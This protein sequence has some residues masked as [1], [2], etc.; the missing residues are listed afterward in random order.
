MPKDNKHPSQNS[1][2]NNSSSFDLYSDDKTKEIVGSLF[3]EFVEDGGTNY[4][5]NYSDPFL[6]S[7]SEEADESLKD[8]ISRRRKRS[9]SSTNKSIVFRKKQKR[10]NLRMMKLI[11]TTRS[12]T[13]KHRKK[14]TWKKLSFCLS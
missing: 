1:E 4:F 8:S 14:T 3:D 12:L 6:D 11:H 7:E 9:I 2:E 10:L 5:A 13:L